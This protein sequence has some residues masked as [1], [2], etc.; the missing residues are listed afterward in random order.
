MNRAKRVSL[1]LSAAAFLV[2]SGTASADGWYWKHKKIAA[3]NWLV[4]INYPEACSSSPCSEADV[5]GQAPDANPTKATVCYLTGQVVGKDGK[6]V[7]AGSLGEGDSSQCGFPGDADPH[8]LKD[9]MRAEIHVIVQEHGAPL[10][11]GYGLEDQVTLNMGGCNPT[12][13]DCED[14]QY[15]I[16]VPGVDVDGRQY[17]DVYRFSDNSVVYG[18]QSLLIRDREGVRVVTETKLDHKHSRH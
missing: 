7:F 4:V 11:L 8:A 9:S 12:P 2:A 15:A 6:A 14:T 17:S 16:H 13:D 1:L 10:E 5:F 18:A 3:T